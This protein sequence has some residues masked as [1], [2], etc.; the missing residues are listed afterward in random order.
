PISFF[1]ASVE[2]S[3]P[4]AGM[5]PKGI[6]IRVNETKPAYVLF[7]ADLMRY[8]AAWTG[9]SINFRNIAFDGSHQTW[10]T[11]AGDQIFG[12][13]MQPGWANAGSFND[14]RT[15]YPSID[16]KPQPAHWQNRAY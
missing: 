13:R 7:D 12:T 14:P 15:R 9:D 6:I 4:E 16:Y 1:S 10:S 11:V 5:T 8:S 3:I 2:S